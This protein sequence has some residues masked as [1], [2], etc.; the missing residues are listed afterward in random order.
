MMRS[1]VLK[2]L[3]GARKALRRFSVRRLAIFGSAARGEM[4]AGSDV[5][6]LVEFEPGAHIGLFEFVKLQRHLSEMLGA[7]VD[8]V[9]AEALR[10]EFRE[11]ILQE[12]VDAA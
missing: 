5:D 8:L 4:K 9:T 7:N 12:L 11:K 6:I 3:K 10:P 2:K 1:E